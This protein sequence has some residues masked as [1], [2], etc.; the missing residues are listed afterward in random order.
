M[1]ASSPNVSQENMFQLFQSPKSILRQG[2]KRRFN[3]ETQSLIS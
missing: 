2:G 3:E 1:T